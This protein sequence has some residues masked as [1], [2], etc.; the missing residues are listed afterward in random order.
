MLRKRKRPNGKEE[1]GEEG[2]LT[3]DKSRRSADIGNKILGDYVYVY[4]SM[5][6]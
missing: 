6:V 5:Y 2:K 4:V 3:E 1:D